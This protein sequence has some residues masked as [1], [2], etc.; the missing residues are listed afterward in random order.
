[1]SKTAKIAAAV[2]RCVLALLA[3]LGGS[4]ATAWLFLDDDD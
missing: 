3:T 2:I 1:M 4:G